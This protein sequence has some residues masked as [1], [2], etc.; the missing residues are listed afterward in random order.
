MTRYP[1]GYRCCWSQN[2]FHS[3]HHK[4][5][6]WYTG[7][8]K[9]TEIREGKGLFVEHRPPHSAVFWIHTRTGYCFQC[10]ISGVQAIITGARLI[11]AGLFENVVINGTDIITELSCLVSIL[12]N[13]SATDPAVLST[14]P[15]TG[16]RWGKDRETLILCNNPPRAEGN[17]IVGEG[18][19]SND[20]NHISGPSRTGEGLFITID[21]VMK[22]SPVRVDFISSHGTATPY[23]DEMESIAVTRAGLQSVPEQ[24]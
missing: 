23:N 16:C 6:Y 10:C 14:G 5:Q 18:F 24:L 15:V 1:S 22:K 17:V 11:R 19:S 3:L 2:P 8:W 12:L 9:R 13:R 7:K 20:A 4:G 21:R